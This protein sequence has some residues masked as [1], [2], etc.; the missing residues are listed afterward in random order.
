VWKAEQFAVRFIEA[1]QSF[2]SGHPSEGNR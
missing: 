1:I 2:E